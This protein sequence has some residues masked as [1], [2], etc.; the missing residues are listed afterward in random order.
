MMLISLAGCT[1]Q[2]V[3]AYAHH[4]GLKLD[5]VE[6]RITYDRVYKEDCDNCES[7]DRYEEQVQERITFLGDLSE[8]EKQKLFQIARHCPIERILKQGVDI[9]SEL[10]L[11]GSESHGF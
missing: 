7:I 4:H 8:E 10:N 6:F 3:L 1:A 5:Q 11:E 2:V 9:R